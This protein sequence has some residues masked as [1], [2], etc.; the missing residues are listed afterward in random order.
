MIFSRVNQFR[1]FR[2]IQRALF[3]LLLSA[4]SISAQISG[5]VIDQ[6]VVDEKPIEAA[7]SSAIR[8]GNAEQKRDALLS[9]RNFRSERASRL[10]V[11]ALRDKDPMVRATA[12]A[13][14]VFLPKSEALS[15]LLPLLNDKIEFV[16]R[17]TAYALGDVQDPAATAPLVGLMLNDKIFEVKTAAAISLGKIGDVAAVDSLLA[18]LK[19]RPREDDEFLRRC[20]ARSIGQ[21][22]QI[23]VTGDSTVLTPQNF[24]PEK[25]KELGSSADTGPTPQILAA[26]V[27][28]LTTVLQNKNES[29]DTRREAAFSLG[30]IGDVRSVGVL[31]PYLSGADPYLAEICKEALLKIER[32]HKITGSSD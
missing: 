32:R 10:A 26:A 29:D 18:I 3:L 14:V 17:E 25:F 11:P 2:D 21:I 8:D 24:L 5:A 20:A 23:S 30:A 12:A 6:K 19:T 13:S 4:G 28:V 31:Q 16:R 9:I 1:P 22:A 27:G 15:S 7:L